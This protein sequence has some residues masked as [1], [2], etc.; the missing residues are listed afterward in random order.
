[1]N[2]FHWISKTLV[3]QILFAM[4]LGILIGSIIGKAFPVTLLPDGSLYSPAAD[5]F[6]ILGD[7]FTKALRAVAP[8]LIFILI[9]HAISR[10]KQGQARGLKTILILYVLGTFFAAVVAVIA[11]KLFPTTLLLDQVAEHAN[12]PEGLK[13]VLTTLLFKITDNPVSAAA[14]GNYIGILAWA[15]LAGIA[16]R[17]ANSVTKTV[18]GDAAHII[19]YVVSLVI[20]IA[21]YGVF[22]LVTATVATTGFSSFTTYARLIAVLL[23]SMAIVALIINP[24]LTWVVL[25]QNP[26]PL[27]WRCLTQ[28]D[29]PAFFTQSS[30]ANIPIN[31]DL[32]EALHIREETYSISI[33]LGANINMAGAAIT[34]AVLSLAAAHTM[35]VPVH[36]F[37]AVMLCFLATLGAAG[38]SGVPG[39]SLMLIPMACSLLGISGDTS[40]QVIAIGVLIGVV[41]DSAE[42]ALNSSSDALFTIAADLADQ[43]KTARNSNHTPNINAN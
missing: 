41:Q 19:H 15:I 24:L 3:R 26:Y 32:C 30:A 37:N 42:T 29:I 33:P 1:M 35:N 39:G 28:S 11:S 31:L 20:R 8:I 40:A 34:I 18:L 16:M 21:P 27:V 25:R 6:K 12:T 23:S 7:F 2:F 38:A 43:R 5:Y 13:D 14:N 9:T 17:H 4:V 10:H 22:G 36:P